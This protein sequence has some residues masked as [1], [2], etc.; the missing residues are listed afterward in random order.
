MMGLRTTEHRLNRFAAVFSV[1]ALLA[2]TAACSGSSSPN[3]GGGKKQTLTILQW[4]NQP[5]IDAVNLINK[6]FEKAHPNVKVRV[7]TAPFDNGVYDTMVTSQLNARSADIVAEFATIPSLA[8]PASTGIKPGGVL[9]LIAANQFVD[10]SE[11]PFMKNY[12]PDQQAFANGVDGK[13]YG[14]L[15][16]QYAIDG[17]L[18][19]STK[20]LD[21]YNISVPTTLDEFLQACK[22]LKQE[23]LTPLLVAGKEDFQQ[24]VF[25]GMFLQS[26]VGTASSSESL[27]ILRSLSQDFADGKQDYTSPAFRKVADTYLPLMQQYANKN[28]GGV[29]MGSAPTT[30]AAKAES[31]YPFF[32]AGSWA[33][34]IVAKANPSLDFQMMTLPST[35]DPARNRMVLDPDLSWFVPT[36]SRNVDLAKEWLSTFSEPKNY[37]LW[38]KGTGSVPTQPNVSTDLP[39]AKS[40]EGH[41]ADAISTPNPYIPWIPAGAP[42]IAAGPNSPFSTVLQ[43]MVPFGS[44]SVDTAFKNASEAYKKSINK[45]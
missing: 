28:A 24:K 16:S 41:I 11:E 20:L 29:S 32:V 27:D 40:M 37:A 21:K 4:N 19:V 5:A 7:L 43:Q 6:P 38:A 34:P 33:G 45:G 44:Q 17:N 12:V 8:A 30:W 10:L 26:L 14:L 31:D 35:N 1:C 39:W 42:T 13:V 9:A 18:V 25:T 2:I 15:A 3:S 36:S 23:G 22:K